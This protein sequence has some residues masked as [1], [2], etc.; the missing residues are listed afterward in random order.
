MNDQ[1]LEG[2]VESRRIFNENYKDEYRKS[3]QE[4]SGA[5]RKIYYAS[6]FAPIVMALLGATL[7][8]TI[9]ADSLHDLVEYAVGEGFNG[10]STMIRIGV[11]ILGS[12]CGW[13][14]GFFIAAKIGDFLNPPMRKIREKFERDYPEEHKKLLDACR[15]FPTDESKDHTR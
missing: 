5:K 3:V 13:F 15:V 2:L 8:Y 11:G 12:S 6:N 7:G 9:G 1:Q 14:G 4:M 10:P